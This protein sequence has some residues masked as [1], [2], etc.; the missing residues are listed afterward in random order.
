MTTPMREVLAL[1][2]IIEAESDVQERGVLVEAARTAVR[3]LRGNRSD[4]TTAMTLLDALLNEPA[5]RAAL[6]GKPVRH[7]INERSYA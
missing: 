2:N 6:P 3:R 1:I 7:M 5:A 4:A